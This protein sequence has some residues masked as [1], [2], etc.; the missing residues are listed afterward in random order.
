MK[1]GLF[2]F[3]ALALLFLSSCSPVYVKNF[4][5]ETYVRAAR[6]DKA[7]E[8]LDNSKFYQKKKKSITFPVGERKNP[9]SP[10]KFCRK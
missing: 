10:T 8:F 3:A 1:V 4:R 2:S 7:A 6:Y 5:Y 9:A